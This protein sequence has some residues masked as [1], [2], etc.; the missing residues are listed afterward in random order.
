[1]TD[2]S[3]LAARGLKPP[4]PKPHAG[5]K[6]AAKLVS[7]YGCLVHPLKL[8]SKA[9]ATRNGFHDAK[10]DASPIIGN[11]GVWTGGSGIVAV[12][13]DDYVPNNEC[14]A[15]VAKHDLPPTFTV[16]TGSG[17][18]SLWYKIP[19][20]LELN[21]RIGVLGVGVDIK[22]GGSYVLGP[23][24]ELSADAIKEG[25]T[26][27]GKYTFDT[28]SPKEF[29]PAPQSLIDAILESRVVRD[30]TEKYASA[31]YD[32][33][34]SDTRAAIDRWISWIFTA[35]VDKIRK[36]SDLEHG[37]RNEEGLGWEMGVMEY[38]RNLASIVKADWNKLSFGDVM[39]ALR[40]VMPK[41]SQGF[42]EHGLG[43]FVRGVA[44]DAGV[45]P[46]DIPGELIDW[47]QFPTIKKIPT[48]DFSAAAGSVEAPAA[49][50]EPEIELEAPELVGTHQFHIKFDASFCLDV[51]DKGREEIK[52]K[53]AAE[54]ILKAWPI[55]KQP[56]TRGRTWWAYRGGVWRMNDEIVRSSMAASFGDSY[57]TSYVTPVEDVLATMAPEIE[58]KPHQ[59]YINFT[60]GMLEWRTG[61]LLEHDPAF[62]STVQLP[63]RWNSEANCPTFD[64]WLADRLPVEGVKLAW[65]LIA[66]T[67]YNGN[68]IQR[69]GLL[70]GVGKSGKSTLLEVIQGLVGEIN[71]CSLSPQGMSKTVFATH[72]LL[73][74]Q[75]NIVTDIDPTKVSETA[76]FKQVIAS[77]PIPAQ[78]KNKPEF[79]FAP[80]CNHLFSANQIPRSSD[81]TSAWTRRFAILRFEH[82]LGETVKQI[83]DSY[84]RVLLQEA[85]GIIAKAISVLPEL[86]RR[87]DFSVIRDDQDEFE[88]ATDFTKDFWEDAVEITGV[89]DDFE[90]KAYLARTFELWC[91]E[92]SYKMAPAFD[93]VVLRLRDN[94]LVEKARRRVE[95]GRSSNPVRGFSGIKIKPEYR[96]A[97]AVTVLNSSGQADSTTSSD[98]FF[99]K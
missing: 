30:P 10:P 76:I 75:A 6:S 1:M 92:N 14:D 68:P 52:P 63:H 5:P 97:V 26:G 87:G 19:E 56:L 12:D 69:A 17:G 94:P 16:N 49:V 84:D 95:S 37:D 78:Q 61:E 91:T 89:R 25:A 77:E 33:M 36:L 28:G 62:K 60:N 93:D 44:N 23:G 42:Y 71:S 31:A 8:G 2:E 32:E 81:R 88:S 3:F 58:I 55:A 11:Y 59:E 7:V 22:A 18:R 90:S 64:S 34:A 54:T 96:T 48:P 41:D 98:G 47:W 50:I 45:P 67:L 43:L 38:T 13:L 73:G 72:M 99:S 80:F 53:T 24:N 46:R 4:T 65:E 9:P 70:Y 39:E 35:E 29:A 20:G 79:I 74:K 86:L 51:N 57:K 27:N 85:E 21:Q 15:F 82:T 83:I 40:D 66:V